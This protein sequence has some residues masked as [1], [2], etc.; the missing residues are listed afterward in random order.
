[1]SGTAI[2]TS[3]TME[4]GYSRGKL[5]FFTLGAAAFVATGFW[6]IG[7]EKGSGRYSAEQAHLIGY[8]SI[9]FFGAIFL[10]ALARLFKAQGT[11]LT[12]SPEGMTDVRVSCDVVPWR[13]IAR[14]GTWQAYG[15]RIMVLGLHPGEEERLRLTRMARW[16]RGANAKLGADGLSISVQGTT[17][18]Y[19][20][21]M[22]ATVAYA[23]RYGAV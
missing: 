3:Q 6:M 11:V 20:D 12:L 18:G 21:L 7:L 17:I 23:R 10:L 16:T 8:L 2:D 5:V 15:Q 19:N 9:A 22:A 4:I 13:A 14:I 1:M